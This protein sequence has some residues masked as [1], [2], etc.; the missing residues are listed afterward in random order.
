MPRKHAAIMERLTPFFA[1]SFCH[2][3][4]CL[5]APATQLIDA[6]LTEQEVH[7]RPYIFESHSGSY[8]S[9]EIRATRGIS[10]GG[11]G[12]RPDG[13]SRDEITEMKASM[14]LSLT[15]QIRDYISYAQQEGIRFKLYAPAGTRLSGPLQET[16][17]SDRV[18]FV[19]VEQ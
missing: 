14:D 17:I 10:V 11:R 9:S 18:T 2:A 16:I 4:A 12:R 13:V 8:Q 3:A 6:R 7:N 1:L 19:P 15:G 5:A